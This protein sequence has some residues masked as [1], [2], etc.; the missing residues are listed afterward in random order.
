M[1]WKKLQDKNKRWRRFKGWFI[2]FGSVFL[3]LSLVSYSPQDPSFNSFGLHSKV[4]NFCGYGGAFLADIFFQAFGM[5]AW[6]FVPF[7]LVQSFSLIRE[8]FQQRDIKASL[9]FLLLLC[10]MSALLNLYLGDINLSF[11][12]MSPGGALGSLLLSALLPFFYKVGS[13]LI[14]V[15]LLI[16]S[17]VYTG[18]SWNFRFLPKA[19][20]FFQATLRGFQFLF[21]EMRF[22]F[23]QSFVYVVR[24]TQYLAQRFKTRPKRAVIHL[25]VEPQQEASSDLQSPASLSE[26]SVDKKALEPE[27]TSIEQEPSLEAVTKTTSTEISLHQDD[28]PVKSKKSRVMFTNS[29]LPSLNFINE[30]SFSQKITRTEVEELSKK[31]TDKLAQFSIQGRVTA[32]KTG[33]VVTLFEFK[34]EDHIKIS[35][36]KEMSS[37]LSLALSRESVRIIAPIP[38]RDVVGIETSNSSR[39]MVGLKPLLQDS[40]FFEHSLPVTLG[41]R[42]DNHISIEDL[43]RMPHLLIAGTTGSGKSMFVIS[44]ITSLLFRH[45]PETLRLVLVDPKQVDL[46]AFNDIPH[47]LNPPVVQSG[48]AVKILNRAIAEMEKRYRSLSRFGARNI[49]SFNEMVKKLS[50]DE[51]A[52]HEEFNLENPAK[53]YY[54]ESLPFICIVIEEFGDLM[55]DPQFK[56]PIETCVVRLA[57][58]ARAS[59]MH[60]ILAMQSPRKD[61]L[62]GLIKTNIPGRISFKVSNGTDSRVILD[63][64]GAEKLLS[65]GD[66]LFLQPGRSKPLRF[67]GPYISEKEV[68]NVVNHWKSQGT[69]SY[70]WQNSENNDSFDLMEESEQEDAMY[71]EILQFV[72]TCPAVSASFLQRKFRIGY[73]RA[74]RIIEVLYANGVIGPPQGSKPREVLA[75]K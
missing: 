34:P 48:E 25:P 3:A 42:A 16:L 26:V 60:L 67:H 33:P 28:K 2:F 71:A 23:K 74:A 11:L 63:D 52:A 7:G 54:Y 18:L 75:N 44:F 30:V 64:L 62:T 55:A 9:M 56:R 65:H 1:K 49:S 43:A 61:V 12:P 69:S 5:I 29:C 46:S 31:L 50:P 4:L 19:S 17:F 68:E 70:E 53:S 39:Q 6:L 47:L 73:P 59:G 38:G 13:T 45:T 27:E 20:L 37:D 57:Q 72:Q 14:L 10:V 40:R 21:C 51:L 35:K 24:F 36:I 32:C 15:S 8:P 66:M 41:R 22:F 58:K